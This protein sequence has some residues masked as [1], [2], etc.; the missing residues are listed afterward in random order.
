MVRILRASGTLLKD[1]RAYDKKYKFGVYVGFINGEG[2][3]GPLIITGLGPGPGNPSLLRIF[4]PEGVLLDE[5]PVYPGMG[6]GLKVT[7][8]R[9]GD[10]ED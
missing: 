10:K 6:T 9:T 5:H 2:G 4:N 7:S 1:F 3:T 8:G